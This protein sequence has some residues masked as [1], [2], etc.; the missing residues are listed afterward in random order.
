ME[1]LFDP[2]RVVAYKHLVGEYDT[3]TAFA[4]WLGARF[5]KDNLVPETLQIRGKG[6]GPL[7]S[8]P[9]KRVL[10]FNQAKGQ[11]FTWILLSHPET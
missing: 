3:A 6:E 2:T 4:T 8:D 11:D 1:E 7:K 9:I 5:I 10:I